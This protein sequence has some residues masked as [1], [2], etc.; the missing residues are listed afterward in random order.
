VGTSASERTVMSISS[1][2]SDVPLVPTDRVVSLDVLRG[3]DM[4]WILGTEE[5]VEALAKTNQSP[6][7][8]T[9]ARQMQHSG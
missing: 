9:I 7:M 2:S 4:F 3:F 1:T 6:V 8:N 5:L